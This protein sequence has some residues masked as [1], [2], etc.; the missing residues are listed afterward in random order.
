MSGETLK[1]RVG[2]VEVALSEWCSKEGVASMWA[3]YVINELHN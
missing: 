2:W 1:E 3:K